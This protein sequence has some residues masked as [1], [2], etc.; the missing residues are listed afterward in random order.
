MHEFCIGRD[1][2]LAQL[3]LALGS[4]TDGLRIAMLSGPSGQGKTTIATAATERASERGFRV[5]NIRGRAGSLSVPFQPFLDAMP[6]FDVLLEVISAGNGAVDI[7]HAGIGI[8]NLIAELV[9]SQPLLLVFDDAQAL[10]ESSIALLPY[11]TGI[12]ERC[13]LTLLFVEQTDAIGV[14][15]SYRSFIDGM[16]SR[17]VVSHLRLGPLADDAIRAI[18]AHVLEL[19]DA[20]EVPA[21][22]VVRAKGNP[23]FARE[24]AASLKAGIS[25][26]PTTIAAAATARLHSLPE[27]SQDLVFAVAL[28][29]DGAH[30]SWLE[31]LSGVRPRE[32]V[33]VMEQLLASGLVREDGEILTIAHPL[34]QQAL[35]TELSAAMRRAIHLEIADVARTVQLG[36]V[37]TARA[38]G[39]HLAAAGRTLEAVGEYLTAADTNEIHGQLHEAYADLV[40]ALDAETRMDERIDL[41]RRCAGFAMQVDRDH[42]EAYWIELGR[43]SSARGDD[44][45]YAYALFQQYWTCNDG[46]ARD[47]LER[48]AALGTDRLGW[49][50]RAGANIAS[51][52]GDFTEA[53]RLDRI[54]LA[55]AEQREDH[56]LRTLATHRLGVSLA[57]LGRGEDS[58]AMLRQALGLAMQHRLHGWAVVA[59]GD[60]T[61]M[62]TLDLRAPE[63][64]QEASSL[65]RYVD[66]LG[67]DRLRASSLNRLANALLRR[68]DIDAAYQVSVEASAAAAAN[69]DSQVSPLIAMLH[70]EIA[71][72]ANDSG[73]ASAVASA[74]EVARQAGNESWAA[75]LE[76]LRLRAESRGGSVVAAVQQLPAV[77]EQTDEMLVRAEAVTWL[78]RTAAL[79]RDEA[80]ITVARTLRSRIEP[81]VAYVNLATDELDATFVAWDSGDFTSLEQVANRWNEGGRTLDSARVSAVIGAIRLHRGDAAG[82]KDLLHAAK[83]ALTA[84]GASGDADLVAS[85]LRQ[86]GARSRAKSRTTNV[87]PLT[88]RELE[89]ARLVASGLKNS[90]VASTLFLA[91]KTVAAHLSNIYGKVEVRSRVQLTAWI[92]EHDP[93]F[94]ASLASAG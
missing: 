15:S 41:L 36:T 69:W 25:E 59:W 13:N 73:A 12:S 53:E 57:L 23:W 88:K 81:D 83:G 39:Y 20:T 76:I 72:E 24:L 90:E 35:E 80:A 30:V 86:T 3:D 71:I 14:P 91:E 18:A 78:T 43:I 44:E 63:A 37:M 75:H 87:G 84:C 9:T 11:L 67:L 29:V 70:A 94:E 51:L 48:A 4:G 56:L 60:L 19:E 7:E 34:M 55:I 32:F 54:A 47:R 1:R 65:L 66:D 5:A 92:R 64:V 49:S 31:G 93:E 21:E 10:D 2:E 89:I 27:T 74:F 85:L 40:H 61:E 28:C 42:A 26:L 17:R 50:A 33:R 8:V 82:A 22:I 52:D 62:L 6:E 79:L 46:A 68:G 38:R 77:L 16:L 58:V 45:T